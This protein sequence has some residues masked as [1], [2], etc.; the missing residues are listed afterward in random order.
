MKY[1]RFKDAS[2]W[3]AEEQ[4]KKID[5]EVGELKEAKTDEEILAEGFD[6]IQTVFT[7]F[8]VKGFRIEKI[9]AAA[10]KHFLKLKKRN[11][12]DEIDISTFYTI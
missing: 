8:H 10:E 2:K 6:V 4:F 5:E 9:D 7:L 1:A 11:N 3:T 12:D